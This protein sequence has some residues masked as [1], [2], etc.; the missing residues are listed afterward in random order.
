MIELQPGAKMAILFWANDDAGEDDVARLTGILGKDGARYFLDRGDE[1]RFDLVEEWI[2]RI[3]VP[4]ESLSAMLC[5][6]SLMLSL[7]VGTEEADSDWVPT[8]LNWPRSQGR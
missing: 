8:G 1:G 5:G 2:P 3:K 4:N 7:S 6:A